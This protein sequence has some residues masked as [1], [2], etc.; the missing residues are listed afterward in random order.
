MI[1]DSKQINIKQI[2]HRLPAPK[3]NGPDWCSRPDRLA[4]Q[5]LLT[6]RIFALPE[7]L[8]LAAALQLLSSGRFTYARGE[9]DRELLQ[10]VLQAAGAEHTY[11]ARLLLAGRILWGTRLPVDQR[12]L[13]ELSPTLLASDSR[14][15]VALGL[16]CF[17]AAL[18]TKLDPI[19]THYVDDLCDWLAGLEPPSIRTSGPVYS[20]GKLSLVLMRLCIGSASIRRPLVPDWLT[21][22]LHQLLVRYRS[23]YEREPLY[24]LRFAQT[25]AAV[26]LAQASCVAVTARGVTV[27]VEEASFGETH[28]IPQ[29]KNF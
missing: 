26:Y 12:L 29:M 10:R 14:T 8:E 24:G 6:P 16:A 17:R 19:R 28:P 3:Q 13:R 1:D 20:G 11:Y 4:L 7:R 22:R 21:S 5:G 23:R 18:A 9:E 15:S 2:A 25:A 27:N